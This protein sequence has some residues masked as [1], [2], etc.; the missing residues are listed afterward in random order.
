MGSIAFSG[1]SHSV[2]LY[3]LPRPLYLQSCAG[4]ALLNQRQCQVI[5]DLSDVIILPLPGPLF[6]SLIRDKELETVLVRTP[7]E[8]GGLLPTIGPSEVKIQA[9]G[10]HATKERIP[11]PH[12]CTV[13]FP[14]NLFVLPFEVVRVIEKQGFTPSAGGCRTRVSSASSTPLLVSLHRTR[15]CPNSRSTGV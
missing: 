8:R 5:K 14:P 12:R 4:C 6:R 2:S 1:P 10:G 15:K 9:Q 7:A 11:V 13:L 3:I